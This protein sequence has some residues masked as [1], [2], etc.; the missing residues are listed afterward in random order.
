VQGKERKTTV[1]KNFNPAQI[2]KEWADYNRMSAAELK[3][4]YG[5]SHRV[6]YPPSSKLD[7]ISGIM[8][9]RHG[10]AKVAKAFEEA[11]R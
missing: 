7:L 3:Q 9:A 1:T 5:Q 8:I 2:R 11:R 4:I 10:V 6:S